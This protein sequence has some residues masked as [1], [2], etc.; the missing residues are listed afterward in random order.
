[1][2]IVLIVHVINTEA[3]INRVYA[4]LP[5]RCVQCLMVNSCR[6]TRRLVD[7]KAVSVFIFFK[8]VD[9]SGQSKFLFRSSLTKVYVMLKCFVD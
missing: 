7:Q 2:T 4:S 8:I 1:M 9:E 5:A 6:L 3:V